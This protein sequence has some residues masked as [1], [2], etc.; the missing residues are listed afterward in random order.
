MTHV[1]PCCLGCVSSVQ[2]QVLFQELTL[3]LSCFYC[4]L[5]MPEKPLRSSDVSVCCNWKL[6]KPLCHLML[7]GF[8]YPHSVVPHLELLVHWLKFWAWWCLGLCLKCSWLRE[9]IHLVNWT[10]I[11]LAS[12]S[13]FASSICCLQFSC[14]MSHIWLVGNNWFGNSLEYGSTPWKSFAKVGVEKIWRINSLIYLCWAVL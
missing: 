9:E 6:P 5:H 11:F 2:L 4:W 3:I 13:N 12:E 10:C 7:T 14:A 8:C 1:H